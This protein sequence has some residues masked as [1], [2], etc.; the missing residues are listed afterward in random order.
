MSTRSRLARLETRVQ[1]SLALGRQSP[2]AMRRAEVARQR[3]PMCTDPEEALCLIRGLPG[4]VYSS[5]L[6]VVPSALLIEMHDA[7]F[8]DY[9]GTDL[10]YGY[11]WEDLRALPD[12][13]LL[14]LHGDNLGRVEKC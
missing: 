11:T 3:L 1:S 9:R 6:R 7:A 5:L 4:E 10:N 8:Q 14:R 2:E 13:E 12:S